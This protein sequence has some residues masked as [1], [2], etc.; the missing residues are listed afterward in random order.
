MPRLF[1]LSSHLPCKST[2]RNVPTSMNL[3]A[4]EWLRSGMKISFSGLVYRRPCC[5]LCYLAEEDSDDS[6]AVQCGE[7]CDLH[8]LTDCIYKTVLE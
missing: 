3:P 2:Q 1:L 6:S 8:G 5:G 7:P 4:I